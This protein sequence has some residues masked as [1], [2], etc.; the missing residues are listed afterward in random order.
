MIVLNIGANVIL[1]I[2]PIGT[3]GVGKYNKRLTCKNIRETLRY[4]SEITND[5][6]IIY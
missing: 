6:L 4:L 3:C 5:V 1:Y 2:I